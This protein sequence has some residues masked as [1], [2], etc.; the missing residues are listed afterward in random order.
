[1]TQTFV[2]A[3]G[4][5]KNRESDYSMLSGVSNKAAK[6]AQCLYDEINIK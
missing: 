6:I 5:L 4:Y 2:Q 1:M 3:L